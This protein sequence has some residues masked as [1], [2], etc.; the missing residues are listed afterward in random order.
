[1]K[2]NAE[3]AAS[4]AARLKLHPL[5]HHRE[6]LTIGSNAP[7]FRD[8]MT[9]RDAHSAPHG[10]AVIEPE[11]RKEVHVYHHKDRDE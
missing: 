6:K 10:G 3:Y 4:V 7:L 8:G 5:D 9:N 1:V 2:K 11:G